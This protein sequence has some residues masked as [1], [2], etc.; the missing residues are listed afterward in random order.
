MRFAIIMQHANMAYYVQR[1]YEV[2]TIWL[3]KGG[4]GG[5]GD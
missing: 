1:A 4:G 3:L 2:P 5:M